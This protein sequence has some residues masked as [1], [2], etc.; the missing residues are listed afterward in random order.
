VTQPTEED[1]K[2]LIKIGRYLRGTR[3]L[4]LNLTADEHFSINSFI[5]ASFACHPD[6]KSHTGQFTSLGGGAISTKS[7]K[8][9]LVAKSSTE[10][11][12]VGLSDGLSQVLWIKNFISEQ[13]YDT[14]AAIV[15]QDNKSTI[16]LA[17]KGKSVNNR[18]RHVSIR[19]FF[20]HDHIASG[21]IKIQ[22]TGTEEM[23]ADFFSKPLQG[24]LFEKFHKIIMN[25]P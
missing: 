20:V 3:D 7:S 16:T 10:A 13:G 25:L 21:E 22:F 8:Q 9:R 11:E 17:E 15:H 5:D 23:V 12:L 18:T 1:Y 6:M 14:G 4:A 2:K 24:S 19:Y